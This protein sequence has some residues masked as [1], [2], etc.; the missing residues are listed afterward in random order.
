MDKLAE[1]IEELRKS[2]LSLKTNAKKD[3]F[4]PTIKQPSVKIP[5]PSIKQPSVGKIPSG[6]PP[7]SKKDPVKVAEQLKNPNPGKVSMEVL[8]VENNGQWTLSK[9]G[10]ANITPIIGKPAPE[11][12]AEIQQARSP[13]H[14]E[15]EGFS[16]HHAPEQKKLIHG[17]EIHKTEPLGGGGAGAA[18]K[19]YNPAINK[20][21]VLKKA[22][23]HQNQKERGHLDGGFNSAK[24][25][26]L[27]HNMAHNYFGMG[28]HVPTT[29]G[30]TRNGED[31]SAQEMKHNAAHVKTS[32]INPPSKEE[33]DKWSAN[34]NSKDPLEDR[35]SRLDDPNH[36][37]IL[38]DMHKSGDLHKLA[39][40][41]HLMGH[42]DRHAG[43]YM[44]DDKNMH[45]IDNG[46]SFD[47][48]NFDQPNHYPSHL[49]TL[50]KKHIEGMGDVD[51]SNVHPEA[52]KWLNSLDPAKA[53]ELLANHG[54]DEH[55]MA[56]QGFLRRLQGLK[57]AVNNGPEHYKNMENLLDKNRLS[58]GP[59]YKHPSLPPPPENDN[60]YI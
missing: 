46:T 16:N 45:L 55:S 9:V 10:T 57:N 15:T 28:K 39:I 3:F 58:S 18:T 38:K 52:A 26:V 29:S 20:H 17:L 22:S 48:K 36:G 47:Y 32:H 2:L 11:R 41:D 54:H 25:E 24:R 34:P 53:K 42:H 12:V 13:V 30:F 27:F 21:V 59:M 43:N 14:A 35:P 4:V 6:L 5:K 1:K 8:K 33:L 31:Y 56:T 50:E 51:N 23:E 40:M 49:K 19:A 44:L 37:K 7:P 60:D